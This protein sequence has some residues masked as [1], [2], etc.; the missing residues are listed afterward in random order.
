MHFF[1]KRLPIHIDK[2]LEG[3]VHSMDTDH[4]LLDVDRIG[5]AAE[6]MIANYGKDASAVA[7]RRAKMLRATGCAAAAATWEGISQLIQLRFGG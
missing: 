2:I 4:P 3:G 6:A 1:V 7:R 5:R